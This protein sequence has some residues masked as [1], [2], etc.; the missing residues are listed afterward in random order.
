MFSSMIHHDFSVQGS[1]INEKYSLQHF[2][3]NLTHN[4]PAHSSLL[5]HK[6]YKN[7]VRNNTIIVYIYKYSKPD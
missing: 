2:Q 4:A 3:K 6:Y 1:T 7:S 5:V